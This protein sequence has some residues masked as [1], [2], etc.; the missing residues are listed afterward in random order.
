MKLKN[1]LILIFVLFACFIFFNNS[2]C[3]SF[4]ATNGTFSDYMPDYT[5][6]TRSYTISEDLSVCKNFIVSQM[7]LDISEYPYFFVTGTTENFEWY[8]FYFSKEPIVLKPNNSS[9]K[10]FAHSDYIFVKAN[11]L[12]ASDRAIRLYGLFYVLTESEKINGCLTSD[13]NRS[14]YPYYCSNYDIY[15]YSGSLFSSEN[16]VPDQLIESVTLY[17]DDQNF[18]KRFKFMFNIPLLK[19]DTK[20]YIF[21]DKYKRNSYNSVTADFFIC[22][23]STPEDYDYSEYENYM[24]YDKLEEG[25]LYFPAGCTINEYVVELDN[26]EEKALTELGDFVSS[27]TVDFEGD[28]LSKGSFMFYLSSQDIFDPLHTDFTGFEDEDFLP[29]LFPTDTFVSNLNS[30]NILYSLF[31]SASFSINSRSLNQYLNS[32]YYND[33]NDYLYHNI[34]KYFYYGDDISDRLFE[35]NSEGKYYDFGDFSCSNYSIVSYENEKY[36]SSVEKT[37][38][39]Y[40]L[41]RSTKVYDQENKIHDN[42]Y[43]MNYIDGQDVSSMLPAGMSVEYLTSPFYKDNENNN[44]NGFLYYDHRELYRDRIEP[45][46]SQDVSPLHITPSQ[47]HKDDFD[48]TDNTPI[49]ND[50]TEA[51]EKTSDEHLLHNIYEAILE[52]KGKLGDMG[53]SIK[54]TTNNFNVNVPVFLNYLFVPNTFNIRDNLNQLQDSAAAHLGLIYQPFSFLIYTVTLFANLDNTTEIVFDIPEI[55]YQNTVLIQAR[56]FSF[57]EFFEDSPTIANMHHIYLTAVDFVMLGL[58]IKYAIKMFKEVFGK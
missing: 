24:Y 51:L 13:I 31:D 17:I 29:F 37:S 47:D 36:Y 41:F 34:L 8:I 58:L 57:T 6:N 27:R 2:S 30:S 16:Y 33:V 35:N 48:E 32:R 52:I 38:N 21:L 43:S 42:C 7:G 23:V 49:D 14:T 9:Y 5:E 56:R 50:N 46:Y 10:I 54:N 44:S 55:N 1:K 28:I 40:N 25:K 53:D 11:D 15:T 12:R 4:S 39:F 45:D 3:F 19:E 20:Y 22:T 18:K 26:N